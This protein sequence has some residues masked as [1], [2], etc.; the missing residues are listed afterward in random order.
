[1]TTPQNPT[2]NPSTGSNNGTGLLGSYFNNTTLSGGSPVKQQVDATVNFTWGDQGPSPASGVNATNMS[3]RWSGQVE[4]PVSGGYTF[5]T[6]NDDATQLW[7]N[8]Q[9][10][11]SDWP[12]GHGPVLKSGT[13]S[14]Q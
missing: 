6:N 7:V 4:V 5:S 13:I 12:G 14:L 11:I 1:H 9:Q 8:G 3:V 10:L 2:Q